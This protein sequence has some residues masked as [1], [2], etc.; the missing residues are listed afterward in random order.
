MLDVPDALAPWE[1]DTVGD[2]DCELRREDVLDGVTDDVPVE[3][4]VA[5]PVGVTEGVIEEETLPVNVARV[6]TDAVPLADDVKLADAFLDRVEVGVPEAEVERLVEDERVSLLVGVCDGDGG[7]VPVAVLVGEGV[8][9][10]DAVI[11]AVALPVSVALVVTEAVPLE[12]GVKL[13]DAPCERVVVGVSDA[14]DDKLAVD[15][16]LSLLVGVCEGVEAAVGVP[17][18]VTVALIDGV[19]LVLRVDEPVPESDPVLEGLTPLDNDDVGVI[20]TDLERLFVE[21]GVGAGVPVAL[22]VVNELAGGVPLTLTVVEAV[23]EFDPVEEEL[24]PN[25]TLADGVLD[26]L[27]RLIVELGDAV[28]VSV[29]V[30]D[31]VGV[32]DCISE[33]RIPEASVVFEALP[34][35]GVTEGVG[36]KVDGIV[37]ELLDA[38]EDGLS[39][40]VPEV[41]AVGEVEIVGVIDGVFESEPVLE[42]LAP[43]VIEGVTLPD[44]V[45]EGVGVDVPGLDGEPV[46]VAVSR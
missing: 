38:L 37:S 36:E 43:V 18:D 9:V 7:A 35:D 31:G 23:P 21:L 4:A 14:E 24:A 33:A 2:E 13:A 45:V 17:V 46:A 5:E 3:E 41:V 22:P 30:L 42:A 29:P 11:D 39:D 32:E 16:R 12:V 40:T 44:V 27:K 8:G 1:I 25:V 28:G 34:S 10:P 20:D 19:A 26:T 6:V 15:D